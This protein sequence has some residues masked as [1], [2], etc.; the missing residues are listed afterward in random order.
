MEYDQLKAALTVLKFITSWNTQ[1][2]F[3]IEHGFFS[4]IPSLYDDEEVCAKVDCKFFKS[5]QP[6]ARPTHLLKTNN[7]YNKYSEKFLSYVY[8]YLYGDESVS[9]VL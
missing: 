1:K 2:R 9:K 5:F 3:V 6:I 4:G 8:Y 7:N